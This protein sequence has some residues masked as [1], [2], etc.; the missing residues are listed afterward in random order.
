M[1]IDIPQEAINKYLERRRSDIMNCRRALESGNL[2][3]CETVGHQLKGNGSMFGFPEISTV[4]K[5]LETAAK[6]HDNAATANCVDELE[7]IVNK[8]LLHH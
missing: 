6:A 2:A 8:S 5:S 3:V 1:E 4:G 7:S